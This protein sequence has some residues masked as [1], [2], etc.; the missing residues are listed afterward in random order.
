MNLQKYIAIAFAFF[1][2]TPLTYANTTQFSVMTFNIENGGTQV[3]FNKVVEAVKKSGADVVGIQ[4]AWGNTRRL[5][6]A[7]GW[8]YYDLRLHIVSRLPLYETRQSKGL[9]VFVEVTHAKFVAMT[10]MHLP[11]EPYGPGLIHKGA[12]AS[13]VMANER[14][15]RLPTALIYMNAIASLAKTGMPVFLTGDFNSPSHL[16]WTKATVTVL[17]NHRYVVTWPVT[18][19][20]EKIGLIDSYRKIHPDPLKNSSATWPSTRPVVKNSTDGF[21]P[22]ALDIPDRIDF[23]FTAGHAS[24]LDS[25]VIS[26][27]A[28][29]PWPSDHYAVVSHF[30]V[31]PSSYPMK[32]LTLVS[33]RLQYHGAPSIAVLNRTH[34]V[35]EAL[36]IKW[37]NAPGNGYDYISVTPINSNQQVLENAARLYTQGEI[38]G[39]IKYDAKNVAGNA[40][41]WFKST[42]AHW[43]LSAGTYDVKLM[44]DDSY[45]ILAATRII[46]H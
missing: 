14:Q 37:M 33:N 41:A 16:D 3:D 19:M 43:P 18:K 4:E 46:I 17:Q 21:N 20:A 38:N 11:D 1:I 32:N 35:G 28:I 36:T 27:P 15:V 29:S 13:A 6:E 34:A 31:T 30:A 44:L 23:I 10:N 25:Q 22:S 2:I 8:Q 12:T 9:F 5:A 45:T 24:V 26:N 40:P 39:S 7:L 42:E